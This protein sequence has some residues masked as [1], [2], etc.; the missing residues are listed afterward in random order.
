[1][2]HACHLLALAVLL[3]SLPVTADPGML[4]GPSEQT[5]MI[6][7]LRDSSAQTTT[8]A[9]GQAVTVDEVLAMMDRMPAAEVC[10]RGLETLCT[11]PYR[12]SRVGQANRIARAIA[13][14]ACSREEAADLV[15][16]DVR[17]GGNRLASVGDGGHSHGPWQISDKRAKP[18]VARDPDRAAPIWLSLAAQSRKDCANLPEDEQLAEVASGNCDHGRELTRRRAGL[19]RRVLARE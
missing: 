15:V 3:V 16:Y 9:C 14:K 4:P 8:S 12:W 11:T 10:K 13:E 1:M 17:E 6:A 2:K 7:T 19:R 18:E 5:T